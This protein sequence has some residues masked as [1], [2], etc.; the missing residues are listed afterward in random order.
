MRIIRNNSHLRRRIAGANANY[1]SQ[2]NFRFRKKRAVFSPSVRRRKCEVFFADEK[3]FS[4]LRIIRICVALR[5]RIAGA[6][7]NYFSQKNFR[8]RK[9]RAVFSPSVRRRKCELLYLNSK[10]I[11][12][13]SWN[14]PISFSFRVKS[15]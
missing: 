11:T 2:K 13:Y 8:F 4:Q 12:K 5:R 9:K 15:L 10:M 14:R 6:N 3:N 7:S 1:F